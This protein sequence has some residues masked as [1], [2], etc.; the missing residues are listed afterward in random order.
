M[1]RIIIHHL[2]GSVIVEKELLANYS[3]NITI[4]TKGIYRLA[5][6]NDKG[7]RAVSKFI[8]E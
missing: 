8:V 1:E 3:A 2:T 5:A 4:L 6:I 7:L